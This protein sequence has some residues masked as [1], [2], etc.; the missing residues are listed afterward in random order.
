MKM[1]FK[2]IILIYSLLT[3]LY[4]NSRFNVIQITNSPEYDCELVNFFLHFS[5][6]VFQQIHGATDFSICLTRMSVQAQ[7]AQTNTTASITN[8]QSTAIP[9]L[10]PMKS[11]I[12]PQ[13]Q[14]PS[15]VETNAD[16]TNVDTALP[17]NKGQ[18]QTVTT[19]TAP[20]AP[21]ISSPPVDN[22]PSPQLQHVQAVQQPQQTVATTTQTTTN[23]P[24][25]VEQTQQPQP[26]PLPQ[27]QA[28]Q[29]TVGANTINTITSTPNRKRSRD[30]MLNEQANN[31]S[32][33][34]PNH[35][36]STI[37]AG[38]SEALAVTHTNASDALQSQPPTK[39]MKLS[40]SANA[41]NPNSGT[42]IVDIECKDVNKSPN[43]NKKTEAFDETPY[44]PTSSTTATNNNEDTNGPRVL[45]R[46]QSDL[47]RYLNTMD[48]EALKYDLFPKLCLSHKSL[49]ESVRQKMNEN[50]ILCKIF[51][52]SLSYD[53]EDKTVHDMFTQYGSVKEAVIVKDRQTGKS[54]VCHVNC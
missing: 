45:H 47:K 38:N 20:V 10:I 15:T 25:I 39:K 12:K 21:I 33:N 42:L 24:S 18:P 46:T 52:R 26:L 29:Q 30:Q 9:E 35:N 14:I 7:P 32:I 34:P 19:T 53:T 11:P 51:I 22:V 5:S 31:L 37:T 4:L 17:A 44:N 13:Q 50:T 6:K 28:Q 49:F 23:I 40:D 43:R 27:P 16:A 36:T 8:M 2:R 48:E 41:I 54:R 3:L 1:L